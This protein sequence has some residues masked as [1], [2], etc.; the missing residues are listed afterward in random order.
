MLGK[1]L[2]ATSDIYGQS[3]IQITLY[4]ITPAA[5]LWFCDLLELIK[6]CDKHQQN[7]V[8]VLNRSKNIPYI[9]FLQTEASL[10]RDRFISVLELLDQLI[11]SA[12]DEVGLDQLCGNDYWR[13]MINSRNLISRAIRENSQDED[14]I[15][16]HYWRLKG[17]P[18][19]NQPFFTQ[20]N[21]LFF[22]TPSPNKPYISKFIILDQS[23]HRLK[24][25]DQIDQFFLTKSY[26]LGR[27][28]WTRYHWSQILSAD[29]SARDWRLVC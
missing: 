16:G 9:I 26:L 21:H 29:N 6:E 18:H 4:S 23:D 22:T 12:A 28:F 20:A 13:E 24:S 2:L 27:N 7:N 14:I 1:I 11:A 15:C 8:H 19:S 10:T 3:F 25:Y 17:D 5:V